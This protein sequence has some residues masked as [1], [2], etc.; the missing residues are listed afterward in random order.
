[1]EPGRTSPQHITSSHNISITNISIGF[2]C[3]NFESKITVR[4]TYKYKNGNTIEIVSLQHYD[5]LFAN[6]LEATAFFES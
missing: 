4:C 6:G 2:N 5:K 3:D 1:V